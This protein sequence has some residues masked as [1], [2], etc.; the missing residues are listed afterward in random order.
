MKLTHTPPSSMIVASFNEPS[1]VDTLNMCLDINSLTAPT[2]FSAKNWH[3]FLDGKRRF[4]KYFSCKM[5]NKDR[6]WQAT[7][8]YNPLEANGL[9]Y[10]TVFTSQVY[11]NLAEN[12]RL[13]TFECTWFIRFRGR[14]YPGE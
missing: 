11:S 12:T 2:N 13:G 14:R 1:N 7:T 6:V 9:T 4:S 8:A 5:L 3:V 10:A